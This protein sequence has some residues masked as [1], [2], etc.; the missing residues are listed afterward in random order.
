MTDRLAAERHDFVGRLDRGCEVCGLPDRAPVHQW[1]ATVPVEWW[2]DSYRLRTK[3]NPCCTS[4]VVTAW[5]K[6]ET[7]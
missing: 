7:D 5:A 2:C 1:E 3:A 4:A 6:K